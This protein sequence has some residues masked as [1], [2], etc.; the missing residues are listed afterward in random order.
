[1]VEKYETLKLK[2]TKLRDW[3]FDHPKLVYSY[4]MITL[5]VSFSFP[6]IQYYCFTP[7]VQSRYFV[8]NLYSKSDKVKSDLD[9]N[10]QEM[11]NVVREL[12]HYKSK[13]KKGPLTRNDSLRIEY[14]YNQYQNLKNAH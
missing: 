9:N 3:I 1:M 6:F 5:I 7:K 2:Y 13:R 10:E 8:P 4:M 12:Q 11:E 14:L